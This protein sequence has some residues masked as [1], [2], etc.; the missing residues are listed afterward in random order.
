[1]LSASQESNGELVSGAAA[2]RP[3]HESVGG[4]DGASVDGD[5]NQA[6]LLTA[7]SDGAVVKGKSGQAIKSAHAEVDGFFALRDFDVNSISLLL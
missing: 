5:G 6:R 4:F 1:L 2:A 7:I 3:A